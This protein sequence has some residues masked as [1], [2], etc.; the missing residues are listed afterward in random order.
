M[1]K[2]LLILGAG[3][4]QIPVIQKANDMGLH[5][6]VADMDANAPG[7]KFASESVLISTMDKDGILECG[8][9]HSIDG[10]LTTSDAPVNVVSYVGEQLG[11]PSMT[12]EVA[13]IC[14]NK[15]LQR[16]TFAANGINVPF[17]QLCDRD[18]DLSTLKDYPYI[19][20]P[21]DSSAS[22]GVKKVINSKELVPAFAEALNYSRNGKVLVESFITGREF[23]VETYTQSGMTTI[24]AITEKLCIGEAEG[25][26]VED[27]HIEPARIT[28]QE[29]LLISETVLKALRVIGFNNCPS[30]TEI[31][32]N[33]SG[34]YIIETA[35]RL[36]GDY[37]TSDLVP[38]STGVD[39]LGNLIN[40]S[41]G[42][43]IDVRP[44]H[45][46]CS[47]VQFLNPSNYQRCVDFLN[48]SHSPAVFRSE[49]KP[50]SRK[51]IKSS[52]DR[53]GYIILQ[54]DT[55]GE[56]ESLLRTIK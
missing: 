5:T 27:T 22:R 31:K 43:P 54:T 56:L 46:K 33:E 26:F 25:F 10:L 14:T 51:T 28:E 34:A 8:K 44:K 16:E 47:A 40:C 24:V 41:L 38:L 29:W 20:K 52:L 11:L 7:M 39:M 13:K 36:G 3:E 1:N 30:H 42:L 45:E 2:K 32:L 37:I 35:C 15:Y 18:M 19:V 49:V 6:I 55:M 53:L 17:F 48:A 4:M 9:R 12:T 50:Y 21:I 23:S